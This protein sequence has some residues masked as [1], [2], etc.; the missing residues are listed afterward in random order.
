MGTCGANVRF[1]KK[2]WVWLIVEDTIYPP[3]CW[4]G[5]EISKQEGT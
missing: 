4:K 1:R 3:V 2:K 5:K